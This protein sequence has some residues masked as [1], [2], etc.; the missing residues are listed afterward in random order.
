MVS[1]RQLIERIDRAAGEGERAARRISDPERRAK[2]MALAEQ[3]KART[4]ELQK[5]VKKPVR[6]TARLR[7]RGRELER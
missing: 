6:N 2:A 1:K 7:E 5:A 4:H 3:I